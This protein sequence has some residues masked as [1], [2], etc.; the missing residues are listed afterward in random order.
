MWR[1]LSSELARALG[2]WRGVEKGERC[3]DYVSSRRLGLRAGAGPSGAGG[4]LLH[5]KICSKSVGRPTFVSRRRGERHL[6][7][8]RQTQT[9]APLPCALQ[10]RSNGVESGGCWERRR[11][12]GRRWL[13]QC[14]RRL[15]PIGVGVQQILRP[16]MKDGVAANR[17]GARCSPRSRDGGVTRGCAGERLL[18]FGGGQHDRR[19]IKERRAR[20]GRW[21]EVTTLLSPS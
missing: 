5:V 2:C 8:L 18:L 7:A 6:L 12:V 19:R 13:Y 20:E 15:R 21:A 4:A 9:A 11:G 3:R 16:L 1:R 14:G 10:R 17:R